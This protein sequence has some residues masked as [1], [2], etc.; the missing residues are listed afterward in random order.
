MFDLLMLG[1]LAAAFAA[2][3]AF[4]HACEVLTLRDSAG[5][6]GRP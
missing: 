3:A 2:L 6:E 4:V 5:G 1:L